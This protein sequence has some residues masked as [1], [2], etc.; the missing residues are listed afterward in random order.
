MKGELQI[1]GLKPVDEFT[2]PELI[3]INTP[4]IFDDMTLEREGGKGIRRGGFAIFNSN[5]AGSTIKSLHDVMVSSTDY[6]LASTS[7]TLKRSTAG[8][9]AWSTTLRSGLTSGL[10]TKMSPYNGK[11]IFTNGGTTAGDIPFTTDCTTTWNLAIT[12]PDVSGVTSTNTVAG[13]LTASSEYKW[14]LVY[15][16]DAGEYSAPSQPFTYYHSNT[17][18]D[19]TD[20]TN[21]QITFASLPVSTD[22]RVVSRLLFRTEA[23]GNIYYLLQRLDNV[24]TT[25]SDGFADTVL[26]FSETIEYIDVP[27][28][29]KHTLIHKERL[30][31]GNVVLADVNF[32][33]PPHTKAGDGQVFQGTPAG[34]AN[35]DVGA[36]YKYRAA[37]VNKQGQISDYVSCTVDLTPDKGSVIL[38]NI[39]LPPTPDLE[40]KIY[41]THG[42]EDPAGYYEITATFWGATT[43]ATDSQADASLGSAMPTQG[44][45]TRKSSVVYSEIS[46]PAMIRALNITPVFPDDGDEITGLVNDVNG[47]IVFKKNSINRILTQGDPLNWQVQRLADIGCDDG[48]TIQAGKDKIYFKNGDKIYRYPDYIK[49][50]ISTPKQDTFESVTS[51]HDSSFIQSKNWYMIIVTI[52]SAKRML[53]YDEKTEAWYDFAKSVLGWECVMEKK[54]GT[55][56]GKILTGSSITYLVNYYYESTNLDYVSAGSTTAVSPVLKFKTFTVNDPT[57]LIQPRILYADYKK[58]DDQTVTHTLTNPQSGTAKTNNDTTNSAITSDYKNYRKEVHG[59]TGATQL[60]AENKLTYQISGAGLAEFNGMRLDYNV[61]NRGKR[62]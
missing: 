42:D 58:T 54:Y 6:L 37:F 34:G 2:D 10:K 55:N 26:D 52:S 46:K 15:V 16:T 14:I 57:L 47:V 62:R 18:N 17:G 56:R 28:V 4:T 22:T 59:M 13:S 49:V 19:T 33:S 48:N 40:T 24:L 44:T 36:E 53:I 39:P 51:Y 3:D 38:K 20:T 41:R 12:A 9:G 43:T 8:T 23:D 27:T 25:F 45:L 1:K 5:S 60:D 31:F 61:L 30:F 35:L 21:L 11:F 29:A 50:P 7:T 32:T